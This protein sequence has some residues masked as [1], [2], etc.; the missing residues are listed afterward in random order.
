[1]G[2]EPP[3]TVSTASY[4]TDSN[5]TVS[6]STDKIVLHKELNGYGNY[7]QGDGASDILYTGQ[8][9]TWH[10]SLPNNIDPASIVGAYFKTSLALDD[11]G[12]DPAFYT[13]K[14]WTKDIQVASGISNLPHGSP[15]GTRFSN[16]VAREYG[17][18]PGTANY[19]FSLSNTSNAGG[20]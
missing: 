1:M 18:T 15:S 9:A 14:A 19:S 4:F 11:H 8:S 2:S 5:S 12:L 3:P 6:S 20:G 17:V 7:G 13:Y 16:W 10:F